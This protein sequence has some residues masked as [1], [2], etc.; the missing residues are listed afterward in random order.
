[1]CIAGYSIKFGF[2]FL[3]VAFVY[4]NSTLGRRRLLIVD[5]TV[6][7]CLLTYRCTALTQA[8]M[9]RYVAYLR[10]KIVSVALHLHFSVIYLAALTPDSA[11][12]FVHLDVQARWCDVDC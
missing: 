4:Y 3:F 10:V 7:V 1:M 11:F 12:P 2:N 5:I 6:L 9:R 8:P